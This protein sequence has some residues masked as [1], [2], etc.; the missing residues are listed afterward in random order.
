M[1]AQRNEEIRRARCE[2]AIAE[3]QTTWYA[4]RSFLFGSSIDLEGNR[5]AIIESHSTTSRINV[6]VAQIR[7]QLTSLWDFWP[8]YPPDWESRKDA[9]LIASNHRC[10][11][12]GATGISIHVHHVRRI[13]M[14][15]SHRLE[16]LEA[17]CAHCHGREH[18]K[19]FE[20]REFSPGAKP[21]AYTKRVD[22]IRRAIEEC[23]DIRFS[24]KKFE[25]E[26]STRTLTPRL[27]KQVGQSLCVEGW[28]HLRKDTRSFAIQRMQGVKFVDGGE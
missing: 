19:D 25:G 5:R 23:R 6:D 8:T 26:K 18:G 4:L 17:T 24:Y 14:G 28:C 13:G 20:E 1:V 27:L 11:R 2:S 10:Q 9:V 15:G 21:S 16:N 7:G 22:L 12:C 3:A